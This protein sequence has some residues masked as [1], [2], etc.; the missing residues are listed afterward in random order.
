[1]SQHILSVFIIMRDG[2]NL[3]RELLLR[4]KPPW[5]NSSFGFHIVLLFKLKRVWTLYNDY[6]RLQMS[7]DNVIEREDVAV[8]KYSPRLSEKKFKATKLQKNIQSYLII[9]R[10]I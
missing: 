4:V 6:V 9:I 10:Y 3:F 7:T 1:M 2:L 5:K 8:L